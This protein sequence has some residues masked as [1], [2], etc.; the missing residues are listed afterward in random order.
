MCIH[1]SWLIGIV[2]NEMQYL[3]LTPYD[4]FSVLS[5]DRTG[6]HFLLSE[7]NVVPRTMFFSVLRPYVAGPHPLPWEGEGGTPLCDV[8]SALRPDGL[9][10]HFLLRE[11]ECG[12]PLYGVFPVLRPD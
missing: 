11:G 9:G 2:S 7:V 5:P 4:V 6:P 12:T 3:C 10:P 8:F 1:H